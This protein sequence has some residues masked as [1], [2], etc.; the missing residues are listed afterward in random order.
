M[1]TDSDTRAPSLPSAP[2][3][4]Q[5]QWTRRI[6]LA[7]AFVAVIASVAVCFWANS[8]PRYVLDIVNEG[9]S[10]VAVDAP[11]HISES[12]RV[13]GTGRDQNTDVRFPVAFTWQDGIMVRLVPLSANDSRAVASDA[14]GRVA[15]WVRPSDRE[16]PRR[17]FVWENGALSYVEPPSGKPL[18]AF[19]NGM[20]RA[21]HIVGAIGDY[22]STKAFIRRDGSM[23]TLGT[24]GGDAWATALNDKGDIVGWGRTPDGRT[25]AVLWSNG[26]PM[27]L[28][29]LGGAESEAYAVNNMHRVLG[30][31]Q[32]VRGEWR[33]ACGRKV[34]RKTSGLS[35]TLAVSLAASRGSMTLEISSARRRMGHRG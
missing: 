11:C 28:G 29:T 13:T 1:T 4:S 3:G 10:R 17:G 15:G 5:A 27:D 18:S 30:K 21:G 33:S 35:E 25:H 12:G 6:L 2:D 19:V 31:A 26:K 7:T 34:S 8:G 22:S 23:T 9:D 14:G 24:L 16:A 20:N 32:N